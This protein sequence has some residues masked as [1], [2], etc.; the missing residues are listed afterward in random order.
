MTWTT[1]EHIKAQVQRHWGRGHLLAPPR[2]EPIFPLQPR[3]SQ[4]EP[5]ELVDRFD[6]VRRWIRD[7]EEGSKASLGYGYEIRWSE[8]RNRQLGTNRVPSGI[9]V[10]T[11]LDALALIGKGDEAE[12]WRQLRASTE[13]V[14]PVLVEW[15]ERKPLIALLHAGEWNRMLAVVGWF[16]LH[17]RPEIYLRQVDIAGVDTKFIESRR[18]VIAEL[19]DR[20]LPPEALTQD[21]SPTRQFERRYG[22]RVKPT[23]VRF[24]ILD[25]RISIRGLTDVT[26]TATEF[27]GLDLPVRRV[28]ITENEING[29]VFPPV[30]G[31][32]VI[33]G[34]GY[35]LERLAEVGWLR[36]RAVSYWGD[37]DTHGFA[38][39]DRLR[40]RLPEA[41]SLLMDRETLME[42]AS[43]WEQEPTQH[44]GALDR[45]T[46]PER[47]LYEELRGDRLGPHVRLEQERIGFSW[48]ESALRSIDE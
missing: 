32:I 7:L 26:T 13:R 28:F 8:I 3:F 46:V 37:I 43:W 12:R 14:C 11:P 38:M 6:E 27:A 41:C 19:L 34:L 25:Q 20:A 2:G 30:P 29:L 40:A 17:P 4:P 31:S 24:R 48:L 21:M 23:L 10:P 42:H 16:Q 36:E 45:L 35:G 39:L 47:L 22:L 9:V 15:V 5:R 1:P 44:E 33:F 18:G